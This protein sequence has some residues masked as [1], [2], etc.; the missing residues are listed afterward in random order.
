MSMSEARSVNT[1]AWSSSE[2][3]EFL[4]EVAPGKTK[5]K[6]LTCLLLQERVRRE[7][8]QYRRQEPHQGT[9][10]VPR[11]PNSNQVPHR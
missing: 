9:P 6:Y 8:R 5:G 3:R 10:S 1:S 4:D 11:V 2:A 7:E